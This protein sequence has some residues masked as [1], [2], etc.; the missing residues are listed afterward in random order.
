MENCEKIRIIKENEKN[1]ITLVKINE[2]F[3]VKKE[4]LGEHTVYYQLKDISHPCLPKI[5]EVSYENGITTV[6]E[7]Y[8]EENEEQLS[9]KSEKEIIRAF[10]EICDVLDFLH[11]KDIIHRDIK[12]SNII[13][14]MDG[15]IHLIDF[16]ASR[17]IKN[18][19]EQ[20]TVLLGTRGYAPPEQYGFAQTD[21][22]SDIFSLG[23]TLRQILGE[24]AEKPKYKR[25]IDKC[26]E[27]NPDN[28]YQST[29]EVKKALTSPN[30]K[31]YS[32][33]AVAVVL[34]AFIPAV[35]GGMNKLQFNGNENNLD[36]SNNTN[37]QES[38]IKLDAPDTPHWHES[39]AAIGVWGN[40]PLSGNG[41]EVAYR[42]NVYRTDS[43]NIKPNSQKDISVGSGYMAGNGGLL[44]NENILGADYEAVMAQH[45]GEEG[46]YWYEV[47]S[48]GDGEKYTDSDYVLC[49]HPYEYNQ[50]K[51][52]DPIIPINPH[53][54][55]VQ[56]E[57]GER[58]FV[59][60]DNLEDY[61]DSD[62]IVFKFF[63]KDNIKVAD[64]MLQKKQ[65]ME[66][67]KR[68]YISP[69]IFQ[70]DN[71]YRV[72]VAIFSAFPNE[73]KNYLLDQALE[74]NNL[75]DYLF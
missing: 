58:Y 71:N 36:L 53:W 12:P 24:K 73:R 25:I 69:S 3:C 16:D 10:K 54:I 6:Y 1:C 44:N 14:G 27:L 52:K 34:L 5:Y 17:I 9:Q 51:A 56:T 13:Y 19:V 60:I 28:R 21:K 47:C 7:E 55:T 68:A 33:I 48:I 4:L 30:K 39:G 26:T 8:I 41:R 59:S 31:I 49:S 29:L 22:R 65:L 75:S 43:P 23:I 18:D 64:N 72:A 50:G 38:L 66:N 2:K 11:K 40:V 32:Q 62:I 46:Y 45:F 70:K 37:S 20:D 57:M 42:F 15:H 74:E 67:N 63:D 61:D 35:L